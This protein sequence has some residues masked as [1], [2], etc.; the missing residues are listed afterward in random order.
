MRKSISIHIKNQVILRSESKCEYCLLP[1][2]VS[3]YNFH[4]DHIRPLKHGGSS[5][6]DN[7]AYCC[8]DCNHFKGTDIGSFENEDIIVRFFNPRKDIWQDHFEI[9]DGSIIGKTDVG[10]VTA[11][12]F[13][14]NE[15]DRL[16]FRKELIRLGHY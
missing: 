12:I 4:I 16:I 15:I 3:F 9:T 7:L 14:F 13:K 1:E 2:K 11:R 8:P 5:D 10:N 6:T